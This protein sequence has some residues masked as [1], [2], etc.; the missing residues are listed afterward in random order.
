V[1][2]YEID[3][4]VTSTLTSGV[5]LEY[6][7]S[8]PNLITSHDL[9]H[10]LQTVTLHEGE[11]AIVHDSRIVFWCPIVHT[12]G[13]ILGLVLVGMRGNLDPY[14]AE[15][16]HELRRLIDSAALALT[17]SMAYIDLA[18][19]EQTIRQLYQRYQQAQAMTSAAI[20]REL[21]DEVIN[22][23]LRL[24]TE[25]AER[26]LDTVSDP[27]IHHEL[28]M[29]LEGDQSAIR[30]LRVMCANLYPVGI[31]DPFALPFV[32][33]RQVERLH[34]Q[35]PGQCSVVVEYETCPVDQAVQWECLRI[36]REAVTNAMKHAHG[37]TEIVVTLRFPS[38]DD[39]QLCLCIRDNGWT[40]TTDYVRLDGFGM[41]NMRESARTIGGELTIQPAVDGGTEVMVVWNPNTLQREPW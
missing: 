6:L 9:Y 35:W 27:E 32:L 12:T 7:R 22:V 38:A 19:S 5:L 11:S 16:I 26:L 14:H 3:L 41:R 10:Q 31:E 34:G 21:H 8:Q 25:A 33:R 2:A 13:A 29:I 4:P 17:N 28:T 15:D 23:T 18:R 1:R 24:N 37:A 36:T 20:A 40:E 30:T 39:P